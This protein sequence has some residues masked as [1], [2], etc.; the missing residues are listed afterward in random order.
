MIFIKFILPTNTFSFNITKDDDGSGSWRKWQ[1]IRD[2]NATKAPGTFFFFL[3]FLQMVDTYSHH[4]HCSTKKQWQWQWQ[5]GLEM[6]HLE[7]LVWFFFSIIFSSFSF[8][9]ILSFNLFPPLFILSICNYCIPTCS[10][11]T[12][13]FILLL[14]LMLPILYHTCSS[15]LFTSTFYW[16]AGMLIVSM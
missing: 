13:L 14:I 7:P 4:H 1:G 5:Q 9:C 15:I 12:Y 8:I 3:P 10:Q 2:A 16:I 6:V 11:F